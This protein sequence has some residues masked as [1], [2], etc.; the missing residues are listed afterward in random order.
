MPGLSLV[1]TLSHTS[2]LSPRLSG[3]PEDP[4]IPSSLFSHGLCFSC[5]QAH[6]TEPRNLALSFPVTGSAHT[7]ALWGTLAGHLWFAY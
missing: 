1:P 5:C 4:T 6:P 7:V 3:F 2:L